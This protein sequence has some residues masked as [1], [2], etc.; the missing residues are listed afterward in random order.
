MA[1]VDGKV[2]RETV[3]R[4]ARRALLYFMT[5]GVT[6]CTPEARPLPTV[7]GGPTSEGA[8]SDGAKPAAQKS[9]SY[10]G[11]TGPSSWASLGAEFADCGAPDQSPIDLPL[12]GIG[13]NAADPSLAVTLSV[14]GSPLQAESDG[15]LVTLRG[16]TPLSLLMDGQQSTIERVE[17]HAPAEH[18][19]GGARLDVELVLYARGPD[20]RMTLLSLLYRTGAE[21]PA[22]APLL[23]QLPKAGV[24]GSHPLGPQA[25]LGDLVPAAAEILAYPGSLSTPP[26]SPA[27]RLVVAQ[28]GEMS[29]DQLARLRQ[30]VPES[31]RPTAALGQRAI[32]L[33]SLSKSSPSTKAS[34]KQTP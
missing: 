31:A 10:R 19:L 13:K 18:Q 33:R 5:L 21:S 23:A 30:S 8:A 15:R 28:V 20:G 27:T 2:G 14:P 17:L 22:W 4:S 16:S 26:C 3:G 24:Y 34:D 25:T 1:R 6:A 12:D 11:E 7:P 32:T 9:W 29:S